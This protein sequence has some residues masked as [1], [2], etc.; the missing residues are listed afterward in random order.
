MEARPPHRARTTD[1]QAGGA[2]KPPL[3][4]A[5]GLSRLLRLR[6]SRMCGPAAAQAL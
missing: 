1:I 6:V 5:L 4:L 3:R 2:L